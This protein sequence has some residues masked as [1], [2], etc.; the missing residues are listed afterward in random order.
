MTTTNP[1]AVIH[2][3]FAAFNQGDIAHATSLVTEDFELQDVPAGLTFRGPQ[4]LSQWLQTFLTAGSDAKAEVQ[5]AIEAGEWVATEHLGRFTHTGPLLSPA[6]EIPPTGR[7]VE[8]RFAEI[9]KVKEGKLT[10]MRAYYDSA[11]MLRQP[12]LLSW[13]H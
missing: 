5:T 1:T 6:G 12:G 10:E 13:Q 9:Y 7:S 2:D 3:L 8:L 4:G 11:T